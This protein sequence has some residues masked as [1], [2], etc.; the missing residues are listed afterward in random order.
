MDPIRSSPS[1]VF[2]RGGDVAAL[3]GGL[4]QVSPPWAVLTAQSLSFVWTFSLNPRRR[5]LCE[6]L[7][8]QVTRGQNR[9]IFW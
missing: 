2:S 8:C 9:F 3:P 5:V 6:S 4:P 1:N 7:F